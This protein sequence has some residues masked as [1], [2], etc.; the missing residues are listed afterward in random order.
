ML[1]KPAVKTKKPQLAGKVSH[2]FD[3]IKVA[4]FKTKVPLKKGDTIVI[5]GGGKTFSVKI[6]SMQK[7]HEVLT[8][9]EKGDEIG[10]KIT[11]KVRE[12]YRI[13]KG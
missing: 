6:G 5:E 9:A 2:Y 1:K 7:S 13:Y 8:Q 4:A 12:G 3:K 11:S 10:V